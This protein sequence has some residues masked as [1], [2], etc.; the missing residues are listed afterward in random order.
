M[1][2][3]EIGSKPFFCAATATPL[4]VWVCMTNA[5]SRRASWT[6]VW[7]T[8]PAGLTESSVSCNGVPYASIFT[9]L[10]PVVACNS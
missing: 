6:A 5:A 4:A 3:C 1:D 2:C 8:N 9:K 10:L 7:M